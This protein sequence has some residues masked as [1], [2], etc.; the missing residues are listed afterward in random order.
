MG[1]SCSCVVVLK[2]GCVINGR[3]CLQKKIVKTVIALGQNDAFH[4]E[5]IAY[6]NQRMLWISCGY[7]MFELVLTTIKFL[8]NTSG[9][10]IFQRRGSKEALRHY[11]G[12]SL[13]I[14]LFR[15]SSLLSSLLI[16]QIDGRQF[17][18]KKIILTVFF[19]LFFL[20]MAGQLW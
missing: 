17:V 20:R 19:C 13:W 16:K 10:I 12:K 1:G 15:S 2:R 8:L 4:H 9:R 14:D 11:F 3:I 18:Q 6:R 7:V 5:N